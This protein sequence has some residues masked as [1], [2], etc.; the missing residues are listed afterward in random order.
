MQA[1]LSEKHSAVTYANSQLQEQQERYIMLQKKAEAESSEAA[2]AAATQV[3]QSAKVAQQLQAQLNAAQL[4]R[5]RLQSTC[6]VQSRSI[7]DLTAELLVSEASAKE[8]Q[9]SLVACLCKCCNLV[10]S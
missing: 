4:H 5:D 3:E 9:V 7:T 1:E 6:D 10:Y 2:A 8:L